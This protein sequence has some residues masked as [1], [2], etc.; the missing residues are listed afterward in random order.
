MPKQRE[1][2]PDQWYKSRIRE[3]EAE[4]RSLKKLIKQYEKYEKNDNAEEIVKDNEDTFPKKP[5]KC[6]SCGKGNMKEF[7]IMGRVFATCS[8]C[9]ERKKL[10]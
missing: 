6:V 9:G 5:S 2:S 1:K 7:E 3:L 4:N 8:T 10:K